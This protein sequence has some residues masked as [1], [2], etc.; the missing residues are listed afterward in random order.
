MKIKVNR[1]KV[2]KVGGDWVKTGEKEKVVKEWT[3]Y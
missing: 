3:V 1:N 2:K